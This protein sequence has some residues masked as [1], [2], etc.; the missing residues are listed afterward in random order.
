MRAISWG[1]ERLKM[2]T[3]GDTHVAGSR[4]M[5]DMGGCGADVGDA[6]SVAAAAAAGGRQLLPSV[7]ETA[8]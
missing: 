5:T 4:V 1:V 3:L 7:P 8:R 2:W 6:A